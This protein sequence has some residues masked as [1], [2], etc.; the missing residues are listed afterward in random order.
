MSCKPTY[1]GKRYNSLEELKSYLQNNSQEIN[2]LEALEKDNAIGN[3]FS[4]LG[5]GQ[6]NVKITSVNYTQNTPK[7]NINTAY[8]FT[9][10]INSIGKSRV[11]GGSAIIRNNPNAI[12]IVTKKY[13]VYSEDRATSNIKGGWNQDFQNT[14]EDF[15]LF[16]KVNLEQFAKLN[17]YNSIV[18]PQSFATGLAKLPTRFAEWLQKELL[19]NFGLITK[20]NN[21]KTG[22]ISISVIDI[23]TI[24]KPILKATKFTKENPLV[25]YVDGSDVNSGEDRHIGY[26]IHSEVDGKHYNYSF[27]TT[28]KT[29]KEN[30]ELTSEIEVKAKYNDVMEAIGTLKA[31]EI[32]PPNIHV[33][34]RQDYQ[35]LMAAIIAKIIAKEGNY[36][37][38]SK[39]YADWFKSL[40]KQEQLDLY[41]K[42]LNLVNFNEGLIA[43]IRR[44]NWEDGVNYEPNS[45]S[46]ET[47]LFEGTKGQYPKDAILNE[48]SDKIVD[49]IYE[50]QRKIKMSWIQGH[51]GERG[52]E[53]ADTIAKDTN[54]YD[55]FTVLFDSVKAGS[56]ADILRK[57]NKSEQFKDCV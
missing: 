50:R 53:I 26:G 11:G 2:F 52:N 17:K 7:E 40:S 31:L 39:K 14:E 12:G 43:N 23:N 56:I 57:D 42:T 5:S 45:K 16:K 49:I 4:H 19:S 37:G 46:I 3:P 36:S 32:T 27:A 35:T 1:K 13:Y 44:A 47:Y 41:N 9:E 55:N 6:N 20:L 33:E 25:I 48:I 8:V 18:F 54:N 22:L 38:N 29:F 30:N 15:E 21:T 24:Q 28:A 51:K 10:N 34:I